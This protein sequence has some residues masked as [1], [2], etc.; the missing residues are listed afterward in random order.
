MAEQAKQGDFI[1]AIAKKALEAVPA[2]K[3]EERE[4]ELG[5]ELLGVLEKKDPA[6]LGRLLA[7]QVK[8]AVASALKEH[9]R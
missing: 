2:E 3:P 4:A 9:K 5:R 1:D 7:K 8:I 6:A